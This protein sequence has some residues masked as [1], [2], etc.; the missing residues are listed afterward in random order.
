MAFRSVSALM[1]GCWLI[2]YCHLL[3]LKWGVIFQFRPQPVGCQE[4]I[5]EAPPGSYDC[6]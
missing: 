6:V 5:F 1:Y 4:A 2:P 3:L